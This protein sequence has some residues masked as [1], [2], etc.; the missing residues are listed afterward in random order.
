VRKWLRVHYGAGPLHLLC[1]PAALAFAGYLV[2]TIVPAP[3]SGRILIWVVAAAI[4]HDLLLW[5]LYTIADRATQLI[6]KG[7]RRRRLAVPLVNHV[8][9]P[10][11]L[12]AVMLAVSFPLVLRHSER[13]YHAATGLTEHPYLARWLLLTGAAFAISAVV[14]AAR[15]VAAAA[16]SRAVSSSSD[17]E[18]RP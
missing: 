12:S 8:R 15:L 1:L 14:Y 16:G 2:W 13:T 18:A 10:V 9:V 11:V 17:A 3:D 5:P 4:A 7:T 6:D